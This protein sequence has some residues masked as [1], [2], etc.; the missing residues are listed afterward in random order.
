MTTIQKWFMLSMLICTFIAC[1]PEPKA[2]NYGTDICHH[3]KMTIV[4]KKFAAQAVTD[5][6]KIYNFDAI[7]CLVPFQAEKTD[8][9]WAFIQVNN[10]LDP[11]QRLNAKEAYFVK[12]PDIPS[13][14]GGYLSA[15]PGKE[16]AQNS[17]NHPDAKVMDWSLLKQT[18]N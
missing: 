3:C 13:P 5:K 8:T 7:E 15:Y 17:A 16:A 11:D 12:S 14:M 10:Y 6:G 18:L 9:E 4:D 2:I 1:K